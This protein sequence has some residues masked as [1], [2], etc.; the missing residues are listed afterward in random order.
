MKRIENC[1]MRIL[2]AKFV[3]LCWW[4]GRASVGVMWCVPTALSDVW[5]ADSCTVCCMVGALLVDTC[6]PH[7]P[8]HISL[9]KVSLS[10][11][12]P[13]RITHCSL[14]S[15]HLLT[16]SFVDV[17][18]FVCLV[19]CACLCVPLRSAFLCLFDLEDALS[20]LSSGMQGDVKLDLSDESVRYRYESDRHSAL[21][22]LVDA[23]DLTELPLLIQQS[24]S[25]PLTANHTEAHLLL[26][27]H[28]L[29]KGTHN[30]HTRWPHTLNFNAV[31]NTLNDRYFHMCR[32]CVYL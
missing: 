5:T 28:A 30:L 13:Q 20:V 29:P 19:F 10:L 1:R 11:P 12:R 15:T 9:K 27:F 25:R 24:N 17:G 7:V 23:L 31:A 21:L 2:I 16:V 22:R 3:R 4:N 18:L 26:K 6:L 8:S 14:P 32:V